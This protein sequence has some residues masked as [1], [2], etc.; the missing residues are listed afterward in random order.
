M[1]RDIFPKKLEKAVGL[2]VSFV[3]WCPAGAQ[4]ELFKTIQNIYVLESPHT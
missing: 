2:N 3:H 1:F 4:A